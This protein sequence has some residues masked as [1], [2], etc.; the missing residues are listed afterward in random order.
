MNDYILL[1]VCGAKIKLKSK[2]T[3]DGI[4]RVRFGNHR[5]V[6]LSVWHEAEMC[7]LVYTEYLRPEVA[8]WLTDMFEDIGP[9]EIDDFYIQ[10]KTLHQLIPVEYR[11]EDIKCIANNTTY[12]ELHSKLFQH[13]IKMT[14]EHEQKLLNLITNRYVDRGVY[15]GWSNAP[16][17]GSAIQSFFAWYCTNYGICTKYKKDRAQ[18]NYDLLFHFCV[19]HGIDLNYVQTAKVRLSYKDIVEGIG[20]A[21]LGIGGFGVAIFL[22]VLLLIGI[23]K[24]L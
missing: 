9:D 3:T 23:C 14:K 16:S 11:L 7:T 8:M 1:Q 19:V 15:D 21:F 12:C 18:Q 5:M 10:F 20:R 6:E 4:C 17:V 13:P 2:R 22:F 24:L